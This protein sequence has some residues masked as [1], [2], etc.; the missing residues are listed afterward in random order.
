MELP[1]TQHG[2]I[3]L[4]SIVLRALT[5]LRRSVRRRY[6]LHLRKSDLNGDENSSVCS[7]FEAADSGVSAYDQHVNGKAGCVGSNTRYAYFLVLAKIETT[8]SLT[9]TKIYL[10]YRFNAKIF[11]V[12]GH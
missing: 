2:F 4:G 10:V 5:A 8:N 6:G 3:A 9:E 7:L 11:Y 12:D 1:Q